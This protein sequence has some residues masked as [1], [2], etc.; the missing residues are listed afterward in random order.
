MLFHKKNFGLILTFPLFLGDSPSLENVVKFI[1]LGNDGLE[2]ELQSNKQWL[3]YNVE[4][5]VSVIICKKKINRPIFKSE[6]A[7]LQFRICSK[8][9]NRIFTHK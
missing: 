4:R 8:I 9:A 1:K 6:I 7:L 5:Y 3:V 2:Q